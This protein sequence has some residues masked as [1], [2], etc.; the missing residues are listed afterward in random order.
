M[1]GLSV[2][3]SLVNVVAQNVADLFFFIA[4]RCRYPWLM[5]ESRSALEVRLG[6]N[7][8]DYPGR[9]IHFD[10]PRTH[11][12]TYTYKNY[13]ILLIF[14][15]V[16][17]FFVCGKGFS[18]KKF[19]FLGNFWTYHWW[20]LLS[21]SLIAEFNLAMSFISF[22]CKSNELIYLMILLNNR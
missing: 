19:V 7:I 10:F 13:P 15:F 1:I 16:L 6:Q 14:F 5:L 4:L 8:F 3:W 21:M 18:F 20:D 11:K 12:E 17:D 9:F 2:S 22:I